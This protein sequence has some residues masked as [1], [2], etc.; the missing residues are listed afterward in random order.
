MKK[1]F[2]IIASLVFIFLVTTSFVH[3][4]LNEY[5][6]WL[7]FYNLQDEDFKQVG[8]DKKEKLEWKPYELTNEGAK[9]YTPL[10]FYSSDSTYFLDVDS[11]NLVLDKDAN[12]KMLIWQGGDPEDKAQIV[13]R[14]DSSACVLLF[15]GTDGNAET[16]IWRNNSLFEILGFTI[17]DNKFI[18]TIWK[19]DLS[20]NTSKIFE[21]TKTFEAS[22]KTYLY[23]VRL[24]A[25][26]KSK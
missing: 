22:H 5:G 11:Y 26:N 3:K 15:F 13:R 4:D 16:S 19:Y 24:K 9:E 14:K 25:F 2:Y 12:G 21:S 1:Y 7:K 8:S 6:K 10:F 17:S 18:P 20:N 23:E